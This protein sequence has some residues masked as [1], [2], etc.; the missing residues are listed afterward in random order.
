V[1]NRYASLLLALVM[2]V[3][4]SAVAQAK[5]KIEKA[6]DLPRFSYRVEG[7][8]EDMI[9]NDAKFKRFTDAV[10]HDAQSVLDGYGSTTARRCGSSKA[11]LLCSTTSTATS[12]ARRNAPSTSANC[13]TSPP[14]S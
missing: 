13:R 10:R 4:T 2:L 12:M 6:A 7:G 11:S 5:P 9:R 14:T 1:P 8:I 3:A